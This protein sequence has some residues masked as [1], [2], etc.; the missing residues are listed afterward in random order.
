MLNG[1]RVQDWCSRVLNKI[2]QIAVL[3]KS[4]SLTTAEDI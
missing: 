2:G 4:D 1:T 3:H